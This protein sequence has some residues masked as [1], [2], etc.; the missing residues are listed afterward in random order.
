[1]TPTWVTMSLLVLSSFVLLV[2]VFAVALLA[3]SRVMSARP[4]REVDNREAPSGWS[5]LGR[6]AAAD[7]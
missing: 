3:V 5:E 7:A 6:A 4:R 2:I 1:M